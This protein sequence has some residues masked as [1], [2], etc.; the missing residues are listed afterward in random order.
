MSTGVRCTDLVR[1]VHVPPQCEL[2]CLSHNFKHHN[3]VSHFYVR[4]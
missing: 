4:K 3:I 1:H 2:V